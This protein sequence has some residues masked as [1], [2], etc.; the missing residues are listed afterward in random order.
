MNDKSSS[1]TRLVIPIVNVMFRFSN[2]LVA[3]K[4]INTNNNEL[5][6]NF[7][8]IVTV[9]AKYVISRIAPLMSTTKCFI[10][11]SVAQSVHALK[12]SSVQPQTM[13]VLHE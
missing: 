8:N 4:N 10:E 5:I 1:I 7:D 13:S 6:G 3:K 2:I 9:K 12:R 11:E